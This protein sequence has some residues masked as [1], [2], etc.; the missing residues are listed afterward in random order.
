MIQCKMLNTSKGPAVYSLRSQ[1]DRDKYRQEMK[2]VL[3]KQENLDIR[4][5]E[6]VEILFDTDENQEKC[7]KGVVT[8]LGT[9]YYGKCIVVCTGTYL[10]SRIIIG[11]TVYDGGPTENFRRSIIRMLGEKRS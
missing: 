8:N 7:V 3:E 10:R 6:I 2:L 4:Q 5:H 11:D 1:I 9:V